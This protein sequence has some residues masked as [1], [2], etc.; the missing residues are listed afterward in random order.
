M[1]VLPT[2]KDAALSLRWILALDPDSGDVSAGG[3]SAGGGASAGGPLTDACSR[4]D[5]M[6][7]VSSS[8][9]TN[10]PSNAGGAR[11]CE[12]F[13]FVFIKY[14]NP[15]ETKNECVAVGG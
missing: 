8:H 1:A 14:T 3:S 9:S 12:C 11:H 15:A 5:A 4:V 13:V 10:V 7:P 6:K 2:D